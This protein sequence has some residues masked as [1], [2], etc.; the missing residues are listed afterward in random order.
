MLSCEYQPLHLVCRECRFAS[1]PTLALILI[2]KIFT[3]FVTLY[4]L[5]HVEHRIYFFPM[6]KIKTDTN[7]LQQTSKS[8][9][10][11]QMDERGNNM[12]SVQPSARESG[13]E[14]LWCKSEQNWGKGEVQVTVD[15]YVEVFIFLLCHFI[16][17]SFATQDSKEKTRCTAFFLDANAHVWKKERNSTRNRILY[18]N[19]LF[20]WIKPWSK[21]RSDVKNGEGLGGTEVYHNQLNR[22]NDLDI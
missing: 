12:A 11:T 8:E 13:S 5:L 10:T 14:S 16:T 17:S 9:Q 20:G 6:F 3:F 4:S 21:N 7:T 22:Q 1:D 15:E 2:V 18:T 19:L